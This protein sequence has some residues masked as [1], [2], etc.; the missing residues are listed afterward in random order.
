MSALEADPGAFPLFADAAR[1]ARA[2]REWAV[3]AN[4]YLNRNV[5][6]T[7]D[8]GRTRFHGGAPGGGNRQTEEGILTRL[9]LAF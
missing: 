8:Y 2:A 9:Q 5:K 1:S 4:W 3:G 7:V 6:V